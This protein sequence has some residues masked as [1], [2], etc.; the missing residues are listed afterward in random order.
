MS[1]EN[2]EVSSSHIYK[3]ISLTLWIVCD[4]QAHK[5]YYWNYTREEESQ[6]QTNEWFKI[7]CKGSKDPYF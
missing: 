1:C 7:A 2:N 3:R 6:G 4:S 5:L